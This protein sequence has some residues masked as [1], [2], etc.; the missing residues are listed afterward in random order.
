MSK[1]RTLANSASLLTAS[2]GA[3]FSSNVS[4]SGQLNVSYT[5]TSTTGSAIN[6]IAKDTF[7]GTGY[8]DFL[9]VTNTSS[10]A[11]NPNKTFRLN[12]T[13]IIEII[14]S[15]YT[16]VIT[17]L[18]N[19]GN[20]ITTGTIIPGAY[21]AGQVIKEVVLGNGDLNQIQQGGLNRFCTDS[22]NRDFVTYSY[23]PISSSSYLVVQFHLSKYLCTGG[24]GND[25]FY[26]QIKVNSTSS[27]SRNGNGEGNGTEIVYNFHNTV[28]GFRTGTLFPL[29]GRYTNSDTNAK[30]IAISA[31]R[32]SADDYW[33]Y[34]WTS[35]SVW[36]RITEIAR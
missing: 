20:L 34:D 11:T 14:N 22:Y 30:T 1:S 21:S 24:T 35:T 33:E 16:K 26:S 25:S 10:G 29:T 4:V 32:E 23:T 2:G 31:R 18:S 17:S 19:D 7:G 5:P 9:K 36:M 27:Y 13:G 28:N 12:S 8:A 6:V 3:N 15:D